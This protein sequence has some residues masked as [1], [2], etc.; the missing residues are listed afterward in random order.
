[1]EGDTEPVGPDG[2]LEHLRRLYQ[3]DILA[4]DTTRWDF[5]GAF[6]AVLE[7]ER[8]QL[9]ELHLH[10]NAA[11]MPL[12]PTL[13][14][15]RLL[16]GMSTPDRPDRDPR[17][18]IDPKG[19]EKD[20]LETDSET[21]GPSKKPRKKDLV[22]EMNKRWHSSPAYKDL[23]SLFSQ[24]IEEVVLPG[25]ALP[26]PAACSSGKSLLKAIY[27][28]EPTLRVQMPGEHA[29][30]KMHSDSDYLQHPAE[31]NFWLP[32]TRVWGNNTLHLESAPGKGD[33]QPLELEYGQYCR[34]WGNRCRHYTCANDTGATR[35]S[36]DFRIVPGD[37]YNT[38]AAHSSSKGSK[39][40]YSYSAS[41]WEAPGAST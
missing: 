2:S 26:R 14:R 24:F 15:A 33:F 22:K 5:A 19:N 35:L 12:C 41:T 20:P 29:P 9:R 27:Q 6:A 30:I 17:A 40:H 25:M 10:Q 13:Y 34:F 39:T 11:V 3:Q 7:C 4:Y 18:V 36:M 1:M 31:V 38:D 37:L 8:D 21:Q 23:R 16:A 32:V 28:S